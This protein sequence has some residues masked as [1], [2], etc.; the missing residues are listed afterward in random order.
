MSIA[1]FFFK[2]KDMTLLYFNLRL[3]TRAFKTGINGDLD[4]SRLF[5]SNCKKI[6]N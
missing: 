3:D 6:L 5:S 1:A 2:F 4:V